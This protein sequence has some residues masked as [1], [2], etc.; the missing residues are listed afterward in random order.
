[1]GRGKRTSRQFCREVLI[2]GGRAVLV[3]VFRVHCPAGSSGGAASLVGVT[4]ATC[5]GGRSWSGVGV[6]D[7]G[8]IRRGRETGRGG[9]T[10]G[11][12]R[13]AAPGRSPPAGRTRD[14]L[15]GRGSRP[16]IAGHT[17]STGE[18]P[19]ARACR[20]RRARSPGCGSYP[21]H[22]LEHPD[23]LFVKEGCGTGRSGVIASPRPLS[24]ETSHSC[25][26]GRLE[27]QRHSSP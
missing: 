2:L 25:A 12:D 21:G 26:S 24:T 23:L 10:C 20:S 17:R 11:R 13:T 22:H 19:G 8:A 14:R 4:S 5:Q 16:S 1:M 9:V 3:G 18:G 7:R 27:P 6:P 15:R